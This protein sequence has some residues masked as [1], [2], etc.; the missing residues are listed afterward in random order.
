MTRRG[1]YHEFLDA[2]RAFQALAISAQ[3]IDRNTYAKWQERFDHAYNGLQL[4]GAQEVR[5]RAS[6][7]ADLFPRQLL[8]PRREDRDE[9]AWAKA[10]SRGI[11]DSY[12]GLLEDLKERRATLITAMR[13]DVAPP[14]DT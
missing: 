4:F 1:V 11:R 3:V 8:V 14:T 2:D 9:T 12:F 10:Y 6:D 7:F 5:E 13:L